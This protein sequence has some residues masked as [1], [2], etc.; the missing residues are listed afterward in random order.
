MLGIHK[1]SVY[2]H[3]HLGE[4][5][6]IDKAGRMM[7]SEKELDRFLGNAIEYAGSQA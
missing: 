5:K 2:R 6:L 4:L 7:I 1:V 3:V